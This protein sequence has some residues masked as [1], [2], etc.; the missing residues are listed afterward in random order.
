[1]AK[2][3]KVIVRTIPRKHK[4][5]HEYELLCYDDGLFPI[6]KKIISARKTEDFLARR[7]S[8]IDEAATLILNGHPARFVANG[9]TYFGPSVLSLKKHNVIVEYSA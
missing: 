2:V 7:P 6:Y 9:P 3:A 8:S 5:I 4:E 1:M